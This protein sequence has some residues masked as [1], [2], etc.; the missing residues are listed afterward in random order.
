[1]S[2]FCLHETDL[3][4]ARDGTPPVGCFWEPRQASHSNAQNSPAVLRVSPGH[5]YCGRQ[6]GPLGQ[7][8]AGSGWAG[9]PRSRE[10]SFG[11]AGLRLGVARI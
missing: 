4:L 11:L 1:M 10:V 3:L 6:V 7:W 9:E 5:G 8:A 2:A